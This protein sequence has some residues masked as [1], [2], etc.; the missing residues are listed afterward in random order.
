[1]LEE[2]KDM[3]KDNGVL[4]Y[5][6]FPV[7]AVLHYEMFTKTAGVLYTMIFNTLGMPATHVTLGLDKSGLP[8][9]CQVSTFL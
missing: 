2:F 5:P 7:P 4:L 1:M 8:I 9:G 3:L 6:T